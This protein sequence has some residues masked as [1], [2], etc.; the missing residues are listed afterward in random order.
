MVHTCSAISVNFTTAKS[1]NLTQLTDQIYWLT[2]GEAHEDD[3]CVGVG[4]RPESIVVLL[5]GGIPQRQLDLQR[6][7]ARGSIGDF[8]QRLD[9]I[10]F[11]CKMFMRQVE[12]VSIRYMGQSNNGTV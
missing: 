7:T 2:Y 5:T 1:V 9:G 8:L 3:V 12:I 11:L 4:E 10:S 6:G